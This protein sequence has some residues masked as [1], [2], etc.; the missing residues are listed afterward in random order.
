MSCVSIVVPV[1]NCEKYLR[2][3]I[4]SILN[5]SYSEIEV[6]LVDDGATD[7]SGAICD[8]YLV[9]N[10]VKVFHQTNAGVSKTRNFGVLQATGEYVMFVDS[11]DTIDSKMVEILVNAMEEEK[12]DAAFCG[13][14][15]E[16]KDYDRNFPENRVRC[17]TDG[18]GAIKEVLKNY[19]ATAGPVCKL[20][21]KECLND[22]MFPEDLSIGEDALAIIKVLLQVKSVVF[23]T[24][25][26]YHYN[27]REESLMSSAFSKRDMDL[28]E[29]YR[30]IEEMAV[31]GG[32]Q[33]EAEFRRIWACFHVYDKMILSEKTGQKTEKEIV[34]WL[35]K[36]IGKIVKNPYVGKMRKL[37]ACALFINK[38]LYQWIIKGLN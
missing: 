1:Y 24:Q 3:C 8:E 31:E 38:K 21:R 16:Y 11:D 36:N 20:F 29:A 7:N 34:K 12:T 6:L 15:H 37:S 14:V 27:H 22:K 23:D 10:R 19:I 25:P 2:A 18:V 30:R 33:T 17:C 35:K 5:Q 26:L 32:F 13:L 28:P 9:D 4:D